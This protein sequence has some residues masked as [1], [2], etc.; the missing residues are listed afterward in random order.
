MHRFWSPLNWLMSTLVM[1]FAMQLPASAA[2]LSKTD[3]QA[4]RA[5]VQAQ[6]DAFAANDA[7]RAF[8]YAAPQL[9]EMFETP[10]KFMAM[11]RT[12]YPVV[13]RPASVAFLKPEVEASV[14]MQRVQMTDER[15]VSWLV[16]YTVQRQP[17]KSWRISGCA[18]GKSTSRQA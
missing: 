10:E 18:V 16:V 4:V 1:A 9:H 3:E 12:A 7:K 8:S 15:G 14:V 2:A 13:Y 5:V 6:L 17:N 11:V